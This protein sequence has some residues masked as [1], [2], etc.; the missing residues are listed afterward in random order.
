MTGGTEFERQITQIWCD[1]LGLVEV[2]LDE[3]FFEL[4]GHS[5][6]VT[7]LTRQVRKTWAVQLS[8]GEILAAPTIR[9]QANLVERCLGN[10]DTRRPV[11]E[12]RLA[13]EARLDDTIHAEGLTLSAFA[14]PKVVLLTG[15]TG[16][17]GSFLC[18]ELLE[19]TTASV[20]CLVRAADQAA[21]VRRV[22]ASLDRYG[23]TAADG[24]RI[25]AVTG[26]LAKPL[27]GLT[28]ADFDQLA[29]QVD[30][31]YHCGAWVN[32]IRPYRVLKPANVLGTQEV[33]RFACRNRLKPVHHVST[34][35]VLAGAMDGSAPVI[36]ETDPLPPPIG[37]DTAYSQSK[38]VAE[39]LI[40]I[41]RDR[42]IPVSIYRAGGV[43][44][45]S[46]SGVTNVDDYVTKVIQGCVQLGLAPLRSYD[47]AVGTV[48]HLARLIVSLSLEPAAL[49]RTFHTVD[50][51][52]LAWNRVFAELRRFGYAVRSVDFVQWRAALVD[53]V[54][55]EGDDNALAPLMAMIG[56]TSE[57]AAPLIDC[58]HVLDALPPA[59]TDAAPLD[60]D[61]FDRM[62]RYFVEQRLLPD[63][64]S[65]HPVQ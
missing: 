59:V 30:T 1:L 24:S 28:E 21:A 19:R 8:A 20:V 2:G 15:A 57:R 46:D 49:G 29:G 33:L 18:A 11:A 16:F 14:A 51:T 50:P 13:D 23:L 9:A 53:R 64:P 35:A 47:L 55:Q 41:A 43:L 10:P 38:W 27:F 3:D 37:H 25:H 32:F 65:L 60:S 63:P 44:A 7:Q 34:L 31:I 26:D 39:R 45:A 58:A 42:G 5:L 12:L 40:E 36:Y 61:Y 54:D 17:V 62:L 52:P 4:G 6:M 22:R 48:D 56:E